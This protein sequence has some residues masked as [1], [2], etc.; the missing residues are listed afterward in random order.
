MKKMAGIILFLLL[1][2]LS[3]AENDFYSMN[4]ME[5]QLTVDGSFELIPTKSGASVKE[6][7]ANMLLYPTESERQK[8]I[9]WNSQGTVKEE[10]VSFFWND[11]QIEKKQFSYT[12]L[13]ETQNKRLAVKEKVSFPLQPNQVQGLEQYLE[14]TETIDSD[15][16]AVIAKAAELAEGEDDLFKVAFNLASWVEENIEYDLNTVTSTASQKGSWVLQHKQGVCDE[17]TSLFVA[18]ARSLGIPAR[19]VSGISYTNSQEVVDAVGSN[20]AGHGWAEVYFPDL[21][22]VSFDVTFN[23][24]GYIDVT[25]IKL[26]DS[27]DPKEPA[28]KYEWFS[29]GVTLESGKLKVDVAVE[30]EGT[31]APEQIQLAQEVLSHEVGFGSYNLVKGIV[32]NNANYYAATALNL[33]AP[34]EVEVIGR[35]RRNILLHPQEVR[36]TFWIVKIP[37][38]LQENY[39]YTFPV[40]IYS[41]K[42]ISV[43]DTFTAQ[44]GK[45]S[46]SKAE[47]EELT[48]ED[49]EK[50][51]S[52]K[53]TFDCQYQKEI[54]LNQE[55]PVSCSIKNTGNTN[56]KG[57]T[58]C[59]EKVCNTTDLPINQKENIG[60]TVKGESAGW[61]KIIVSAENHE[62]EKKISLEYA[63]VDVPNVTISAKYPS[64]V[65]FGNSFALE[66]MINK[67]SFQEPKDLEVSISGA[68]LKSVWDIP[69]LGKEEKIS[70]SVAG[71]ALSWNTDFII[72]AKW[73][74]REGKT[75]SI[76]EKITI[77]AEADSFKDKVKMLSNWLVNLFSSQSERINF[78][79]NE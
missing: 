32:K 47:I 13:I 55:A 71:E 72:T 17:M 69:K 76:Q 31:L 53:I 39:V 30:K 42:N 23:Q 61:K 26:R 59:V 29:D 33:A 7:T 45:N 66:I 38:N 5:L 56:L 46:Y 79:I 41:E 44:A 54:M 78:S 15:H 3:L 67:E 70:Y 35:N 64:L 11:K 74:D 19:F 18:M 36:E 50:S 4:T 57:L 73:E 22:W 28:V 77:K 65:Q 40:R 27:F 34:K 8:I 49:E 51:Y 58:F 1:A 60:I 6:V 68:G 52:Q 12:A 10:M 48:I 43:D 14:P 63:V 21:G 24:Y 2:S 37:E 62:V 75:Y 25:H 20:W 16:P 9:Q